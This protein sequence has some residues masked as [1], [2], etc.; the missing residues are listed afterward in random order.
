MSAWRRLLIVAVALPI[1]APLAAQ[2]PGPEQVHHALSVSLDPATRRL[3]VE[4]EITL[5]G[6]GMLEVALGAQLRVREAALNGRMLPEPTLAPAEQRWTID[7]GARAEQRLAFRYEGELAPLAQADHRGVLEALPPMAAERGSYLP[8]SSG[9]YPQIG[10][11][12]F[13]Y[14]LRLALPPG[15]RGLA[16]GA[17]SDEH[18]DAHGYRATFTFARPAEGID[19]FAAPYAV[20]ERW[21]DRAGE[22]IRLRAW[23]H[24]EIAALSTDYLDAAARYMALYEDWIG[25]YPFG[26]FSIV[27]SPLPTGFG[28]PSMTYLGIDVLRLPFIKSTSL[29][30]EVLHNWWGNGVYVDH[31][32]GNWAEG[33]TTFMADYAYKEQDGAPAA[34]SLR[35]DWLRDF[36]AVPAGQDAPLR[37]FTAR[38]HGTSQIVGYHKAA[39]V[40]LML[41]DTLGASAFDAGLQRFWREQR[42]QR[43]SWA[44]LQR[45]FE[46]ASERP[47]GDFFEEW[48]T[49]GG[50]PRIW[51]EHAEL[52]R[53]GDRFVVRVRLAQA[54]PAYTLGVPLVIESESGA[55]THPV[56]L[57]GE[58]GEYELRSASRPRALLLD[59]DLRLF[60][61]LEQSELPPILRQVMLDPS[62][63]T[64]V[65]ELDAAVRSKAQA[66]AAAL[67][68]HAP[69]LARSLPPHAAPVLLIGTHASVESFLADNDLPATP[70]Q[71]AGKGS[72]RS[73]T[74]RQRNGAALAV[75]SAEDA[76]AIA[77]L[78]GPLPHYGRQSWV[79]FHGAQ[80]IDRGVWPARA[81]GWQFEQ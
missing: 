15:Q 66:L 60:R 53:Q 6:G 45:A 71:A 76:A 77:A 67:L 79:V 34:R 81:R 19:L 16:P 61:H 75:V 35:L 42:F 12:P 14:R 30:H 26:E 44:D 69:R 57:S 43:A 5:R 11:Q 74:A 73:W 9:W 54:P 25:A 50:A 78:V 41:R 23:F 62:V 80:A 17:L 10:A 13:T 20:Q 32:G 40:F 4:D 3:Q 58:R 72:A 8:A 70:P 31:A 51:I 55:Q 52:A 24:P 63:V 22:P 18:D 29:G 56:R 27:S 21:I 39:F 37:A 36:G 65:P 59:P 1:L 2:D 68:D 46:Q 49:R 7:L 33:L 38:S 47:L 48:L 64:V 28:M